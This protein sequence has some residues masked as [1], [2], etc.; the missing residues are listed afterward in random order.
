[1]VRNLASGIAIA[2][3]ASLPF[4]TN[5]QGTVDIG[6]YQH[7]GNLEVKVRPTSEFDGVF[8]SVVFTL[9]WDKSTGITPGE[10]V[11]PEGTPI[12]TT[13]SGQTHEE[14]VFNYLVFAGF[15]FD[16]MSASGQ[17]YEA[18]KEYTILTIPVQGK[19][20]VELVN[21]TWTNVPTN[22]ADY[23]VSL[24][25][26]DKTGTIYKSLAATTDLDGSVTI[27]PNPNNG[28][29]QFS[30]IC[31]E[32][33]DLRVE[34]VNNLGQTSFSETLRGFSGSYVKD[35][36]LTRESEGAYYLKITRGANTG[37]HKIVYQR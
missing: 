34:V 23:Y 22:N 26:Y 4:A 37:T 14:G 35:M 28:L 2:A 5:A 33:S 32:P 25:G 30:F 1:M 18:G 12:R 20:A 13:R 17:R 19:G 3:L 10:A 24:G 11:V 7:N 6:L 31:D 36:D 8:S 16:V 15:G 29:F 21:D 9:R 27:K